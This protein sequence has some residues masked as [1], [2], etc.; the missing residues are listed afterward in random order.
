M[1]KPRLDESDKPRILSHRQFQLE[2]LKEQKKEQVYIIIIN[3]N[4][5]WEK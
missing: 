1:N 3:D 5:E 2:E 4:R